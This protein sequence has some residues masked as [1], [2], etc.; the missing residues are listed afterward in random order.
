MLQRLCRPSA[1]RLV[2]KQDFARQHWQENDCLACK[3]QFRWLIMSAFPTKMLISSDCHV[4]EMHPKHHLCC[5][6]NGRMMLSVLKV[7]PTQ[8]VQTHPPTPPTLRAERAG[9]RANGSPRSADIL[10][11]VSTVWGWVHTPAVAQYSRASCLNIQHVW[12]DLCSFRPLYVCN[13]I[14]MFSAGGSRSAAVWSSV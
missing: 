4:C 6:F 9:E 13:N 14:I 5:F 7:G 11:N 12:D 8:S 10:L 2:W 3:I 1:V